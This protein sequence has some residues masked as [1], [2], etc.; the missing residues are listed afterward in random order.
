M[1]LLALSAVG[2]ER[3]YVAFRTFCKENHLAINRDK[4][5]AM[6]TKQA[7]PTLQ[8]GGDSFAVVGSFRYLGVTV[9][10]KGSPTTIST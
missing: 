9:D 7:P 6:V 1:A 8:L 10:A 4:T 2:L 5:V 3:L